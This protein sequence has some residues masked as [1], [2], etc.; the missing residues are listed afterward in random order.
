MK[1]IIICL[2]SFIISGCATANNASNFMN[3]DSAIEKSCQN[4]QND[5]NENASIAIFNISSSSE[6]LSEYL[7]EEAMNSFTN[8]HKYNIVERSKISTIIQ[9]QNF[10]LA[11]NV[12]D[13]TMQRIGNMLG[14]QFVVTGA[15][16]DVGNYYRLRLFVIAIESS[17]R[18]SSTAVNIMKPNKQIAYLLSGSENLETNPILSST[19]N[20]V[21][22][23]WSVNIEGEEENLGIFIFDDNNVLRTNIFDSYSYDDGDYT[24]GIWNWNQS[25]NKLIIRVLETDAEEWRFEFDNITNLSM[26]GIV[27]EDGEILGKTEIHR[28]K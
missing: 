14:A 8:M 12:S 2:V 22:T 5:F 15:L 20:L 17:E 18:K 9:E 4:I 3:L 25:R 19:V 11:G 24:L 23:T 10:Q 21:G 26:Y 27:F 1:R 16:V 7:V 28:T 6:R 13:D